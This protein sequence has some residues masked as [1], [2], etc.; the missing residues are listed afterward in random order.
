MKTINISIT[1][2]EC[3]R[4]GIKRENWSLDEFLELVGKEIN[5]RDLKRS[6]E[7]AEKSNLDSLSMGQITK[8]VKA[9]RKHAKNNR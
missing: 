3:K 6:L 1:E 5:R 7:L 2:S 9:V 8:E 4:Y